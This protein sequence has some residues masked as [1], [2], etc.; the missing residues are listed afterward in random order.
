MERISV[1]QLNMLISREL[2]LSPRLNKI[3]VEAEIGRLTRHGSGHYYF[4]IKDHYS[5][6]DCVMYRSSVDKNSYSFDEGDRVLL[7]GS[8][9]FYE[10]TGRLQFYVLSVQPLGEGELLKAFYALKEKFQSEGLLD[11]LN[12]KA[13]PRLPQ[14]IA[15]LTSPTG[16][17]YEDFMKVF[18]QRNPF[19]EVLLYPVTVQGEKAVPS[20]LEA[21]ETVEADLIVLTR[22]GGSYEDLAVF[23]D[24]TLCRR[25]ASLS[26]P[27]LCA[28]GHEI[29]FTLAELVCDLRAATPTQA[30]QLASDDAITLIQTLMSKLALHAKNRFLELEN[31]SFYLDSKIDK[32]RRSIEQRLINEERNLFEHQRELRQRFDKIFTKEKETADR[33]FLRI[34][35]YNPDEILKRG[36]IAVKQEHWVLRKNQLEPS[37][38]ELHFYDGIKKVEIS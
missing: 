19:C 32:M 30:A 14:K 18:T 25:L 29:D 21:L 22:G 7:K 36:Y 13:L 6:I 5:A 27:C 3:Q 31:E 37:P 8:V 33:F 10:K 1:S 23:N 20:I 2:A 24:E 26:T 35:G 15:I 28:I 11:P 38:A 12:K 16:A 4:S 17:A 9:S 34:E